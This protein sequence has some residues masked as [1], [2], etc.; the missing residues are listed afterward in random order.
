MGGLSL[1]S[2]HPR[3]NGANGINGGRSAYIPP[4]MRGMPGGGMDGPPPGP[5]MN[6]ASRY[7]NS[8]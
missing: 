5:A 1:D 3:A 8:T 6:G 7:G 4:H 2:Q